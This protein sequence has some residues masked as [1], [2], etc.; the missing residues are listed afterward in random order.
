MALNGCDRLPYEFVIWVA[1]LTLSQRIYMMDVLGKVDVSRIRMKSSDHELC[2]VVNI[3][4]C[5]EF[6]EKSGDL[7]VLVKIGEH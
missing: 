6:M 7:D 3:K 4:R 2:E 5:K 1:T